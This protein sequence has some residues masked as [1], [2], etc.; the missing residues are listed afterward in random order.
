MLEI[1][2][3]EQSGTSLKQQAYV[4]HGDAYWICAM[5]ATYPVTSRS[6]QQNTALHIED[7]LSPHHISFWTQANVAF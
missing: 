1:W 7:D 5:Y 2:D 3:R 6:G 4:Y